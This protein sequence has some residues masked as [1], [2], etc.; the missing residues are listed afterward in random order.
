MRRD[1]RPGDPLRIP[2]GPGSGAANAAG[3][4]LTGPLDG[5]VPDKPTLPSASAWCVP[6]AYAAF[7]LALPFKAPGLTSLDYGLIT[8]STSNYNRINVR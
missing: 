7:A 4:G 2:G 1:D 8:V 6:V 3:C 5:L